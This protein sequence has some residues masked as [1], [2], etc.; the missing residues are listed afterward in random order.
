MAEC[1]SGA[2]RTCKL[3][4]EKGHLYD[5]P[6]QKQPLFAFEER[7]CSCCEHA[8]SRALPVGEERV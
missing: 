6:W 2:H 5:R 4:M 3:C 7:V 8:E 1:C